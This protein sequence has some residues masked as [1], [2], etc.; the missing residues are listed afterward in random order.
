ML[1][2]KIKKFILFSIFISG[3]IFSG[4]AFGYPQHGLSRYGNLKYTANFQNFDYVNPNAPKGGVLR[5]SNLGSF[6][7]LNQTIKGTAPEGLNLTYDSLLARAADEPFS[8]YGLVAETVDVAPDNTWVIF[9][10]RPEARFHDGTPITPEDVIFSWE[11]QK[12]KGLPRV[13]LHY[14]KVEKAEKIGERSVKFTFKREEDGTVDPERPMIMGMM[15]LY[16]KRD[17][18]GKEFDTVML[19]PFLGSGPYRISKFEPGRFIEYERVKDY[20]ASDLPVRK[21]SHNF[22]LIRYEYFKN[23]NVALEAFKAGQYDIIHE[24]DLNRWNM[25]YTG[26]A[27]S[28]QRIKKAELDHKRPTGIK[29]FVFNTRREIFKDKRVRE[30]L[31]LLFDF[32]WMNK[33]LFDNG[34]KRTESYFENSPLKAQGLPEGDEKR[35][36]LSLKDKLDSSILQEKAVVPP[37]FDGSGHNRSAQTQ[38]LNLLKEAGW[39]LQN[40]KLIN[41]KTSQP[42]TFEILLSEPQFEKPALAFA[43]SLKRI[44]IEARIRMVDSAQYEERRLEWDYDMI[45]NWWASTLTPGNE[46]YLYWTKKAADTSGCRNYAGIREEV[47]DILTDKLAKA[48]TAEA[49]EAAARALDR[50]LRHGYYLVPLYFSPMDRFAYWDKFGMPPWR[51]EIGPL[52]MAWWD[53]SKGSEKNK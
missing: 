32:E 24:G 51:A 22:D 11:I 50:V 19:K 53:K 42:F 10:I 17:W 20:W 25:A 29:G 3:L 43:R 26:P 15:P 12:N 31:S 4:Q 41:K 16:S 33:N 49:V 5:L 38:A 13:R 14:S 52:M 21:G 40:G 18:T 1:P 39:I 8:M 6:D 23:A 46:Q 47:V 27:F 34:F 45:A 9:T 7:T 35:L 28:D 30:A 48:S 37:H 44:G 36:L 2:S